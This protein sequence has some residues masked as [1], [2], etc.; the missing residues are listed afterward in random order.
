[1][2]QCIK[3]LHHYYSWKKYVLFQKI[4]VKTRSIYSI[5]QPIICMKSF[6]KINETMKKSCLKSNR[7]CMTSLKHFKKPIRTC[8]KSRRTCK[9]S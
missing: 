6:R 2:N 8:M 9:K 3:M 1:M 4:D 5:E 7:T